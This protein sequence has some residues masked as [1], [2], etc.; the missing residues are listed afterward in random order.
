MK[1][2]VDATKI[3]KRTKVG[4]VLD[5]TFADLTLFQ[6]FHQLLL[7]VSSLFLDQRTT[8]YNNVS[9]LGVNLEN[10]TLNDSTNV[11]ADVARATNVDLRS[12]QEY[13]N[14]DVDEQAAFDFASTSTSDDIAFGNF[15]NNGFPFDNVVGFSLADRDQT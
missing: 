8:R 11:I 1:Q 15:G 6:F 12:R 13:R 10:F 9:T 2:A 3:D 4:D 14:T 5:D 7:R